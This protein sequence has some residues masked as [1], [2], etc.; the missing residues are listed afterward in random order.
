MNKRKSKKARI[1]PT[2]MP[3]L[4]RSTE[5]AERTVLAADLAGREG[6]QLHA[7]LETETR[8]SEL[9]GQET[10]AKL[11]PI[12]PSELDVR[13]ALLLQPAHP[14]SG[15]TPPIEAPADV[16]ES[17]HTMGEARTNDRLLE[18]DGPRPAIAGLEACQAL[19]TEIARDNLDFAARL[20]SMRSPLEI[21][22]IATEF[23]SS[24][25]GTYGRFSKAVADIAS[26]RPVRWPD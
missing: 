3:D 13:P 18:S 11:P 21:V 10:E 26:G 2:A 25:I 12:P 17:A 22:G 7:R 23:A 14:S 5:T 16:K 19:L 15:V 24:Q 4:A 1:I 6:E 8:L 20:A 9:L